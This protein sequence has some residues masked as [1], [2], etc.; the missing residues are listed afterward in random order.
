[1]ALGH[2]L[3]EEFDPG[4]PDLFAHGTVIRVL[5]SENI[6]MQPGTLKSPRLQRILQGMGV[7]DVALIGD[8]VGTDTGVGSTV[9][10]VGVPEL[11]G[12]EHAK[13]QHG[14]LPGTLHVAASGERK[15]VV[16]KPF[17]LDP[18]HRYN[19]AHERTSLQM[20]IA[21]CGMAN[22]INSLPSDLSVRAVRPVGFWR[23][24]RYRPE[25]EVGLRSLDPPEIALLTE[26]EPDT[27]TL[28]QII[29]QGDKNA[30]MQA[31]AVRRSSQALA[32]LHANGLAHGDTALRNFMIRTDGTVIFS[33]LAGGMT[34]QQALRLRKRGYIDGFDWAKQLD[35]A[36]LWGELDDSAERAISWHVASQLLA[37]SHEAYKETLAHFANQ[38]P[39]LQTELM[40]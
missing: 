39:T 14:S 18:L 3:S 24:D 15:D 1:M 40:E 30:D 26:Y 21:E 5:T 35:Q 16:L 12:Q 7:G 33:D 36:E 17:I 31:W 10:F 25:S 4:Q 22:A 23:Y 9:S 2:E 29:G 11:F 38:A 20:L 37:L 27:M 6:R 8:I 34:Q 28:A 13:G 19:K 32:V